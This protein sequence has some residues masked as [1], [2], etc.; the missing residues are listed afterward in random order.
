MN[1]E[2]K[3]AWGLLFRTVE[4]WQ[5]ITTAPKD[6]TRVE[7]MN[8]TTG[9]RDVGRWEDYTSDS[10]STIPGEW[11]TDLGNGDM[12]HWRPLDPANYRIL[13]NPDSIIRFDTN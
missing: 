7:L 6:G 5:D 2:R 10:L 8:E 1:D 11:N 4:G 12:T 3:K 13:K 9:L